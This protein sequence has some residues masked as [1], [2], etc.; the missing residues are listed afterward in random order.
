MQFWGKILGNSVLD[1][2]WVA[3]YT[4]I[5]SNLIYVHPARDF[6]VVVMAFTGLTQAGAVSLEICLAIETWVCKDDRSRHGKN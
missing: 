5:V 2:L 6:N 1:L 3:S 4:A